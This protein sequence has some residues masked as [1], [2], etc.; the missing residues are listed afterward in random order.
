M[1]SEL[2]IGISG[3]AEHGK[4]TLADAINGELFQFARLTRRNFADALKEDAYEILVHN[5][6]HEG[7]WRYRWLEDSPD[8][9]MTPLA[10]INRLKSDPTYGPTIRTFLQVYGA[11]QRAG[12]PDYWIR[13][14]MEWLEMHKATMAR[15]TYQTRPAVYYNGLI[16]SDV[17]YPNEA[18]HIR[19]LGGL[20]LRVERFNEDGT[21]YQ[22]RL[23]PLAQAHDSE[24]AL[25]DYPHF[26]YHI[27]NVSGFKIDVPTEVLDYATSQP[28]ADPTRP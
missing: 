9:P 1:T 16:V 12:N 4:D 11:T 20:V 27:S 7:A 26:A 23:S 3:K 13:R 22:N 17:R 10:F 24:T 8:G 18:E 14:L 19:A 2:I 25:D 15:L 21:P 5:L 6:R 28:R